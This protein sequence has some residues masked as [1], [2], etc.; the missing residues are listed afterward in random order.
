MPTVAHALAC[1]VDTRV[2]DRIDVEM[3][4]DTAR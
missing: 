1:S 2:D 4:L 3:S